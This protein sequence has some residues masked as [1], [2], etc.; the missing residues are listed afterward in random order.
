MIHQ[1]RALTLPQRINHGRLTGPVGDRPAVC[2]SSIRAVPAARKCAFQRSADEPD[3]PRTTARFPGGLHLYHRGVTSRD[4]DF[5]AGLELFDSPEAAALSGW[6]STPSAH[7]RVIDVA[8]GDGFEGVWVTM[9]IDGYSGVV[10]VDTAVCVRAPN[11]KWYENGS[12]G[13]H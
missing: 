4:E 7:A 13:A 9:Q 12:S 8:P 3:G 10:D 5:L 6:R 11:G 1:S 2:A